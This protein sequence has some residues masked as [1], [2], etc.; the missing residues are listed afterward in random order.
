[1]CKKILKMFFISY[2]SLYSSPKKNPERNLKN[3]EN[4]EE[5][6]NNKSKIKEKLKLKMAN[7]S[8]KK[9]VERNKFRVK[10]NCAIVFSSIVFFLIWRFF[11]GTLSTGAYV[12]FTINAL[13]QLGTFFYTYSISRPTYKNGE[14]IDCGS[15]LSDPGLL[16][17][18]HDLMYF[19]SI[20]QIITS[21]TLFSMYMYIIIIVYV[22]FKLYSMS[23]S[24]G[25][26]GGNSYN[27]S[28]VPRKE[29]KQKVK[30]KSYRK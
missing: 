10:I 18:I 8:Q 22:L 29:K 3:K 30:Y 27:E 26:L 28:D 7:N 16:D 15:D 12:C 13:F 5:L 21:W 4:L 23:K 11:R 1:M 25:G 9:T 24:F 6:K 20:I 19:T 14:L 2:I 17:F